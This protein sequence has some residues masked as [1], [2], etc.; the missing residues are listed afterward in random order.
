MS[1]CILV[2]STHTTV[3][4]LTMLSTVVPYRRYLH[5]CGR[6]LTDFATFRRSD[7]VTTAQNTGVQYSGTAMTRMRRKAVATGRI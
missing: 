7:S 3:N 1:A 4:G 5:R 6:R 2:S